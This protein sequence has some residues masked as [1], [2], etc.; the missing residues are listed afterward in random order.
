MIFGVEVALYYIW[1]TKV[2]RQKQN[3][4]S[5]KFHEYRT[6]LLLPYSLLHG[7]TDLP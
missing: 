6:A 2:D 4:S 7:H 3:A 5:L 1:F